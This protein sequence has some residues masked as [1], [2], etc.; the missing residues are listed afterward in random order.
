M[1]KLTLLENLSHLEIMRMKAEKQKASGLN[2]I[3]VMA[4]EEGE[5]KAS[6]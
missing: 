2:K 6:H 4:E 1:P 3:E 5:M